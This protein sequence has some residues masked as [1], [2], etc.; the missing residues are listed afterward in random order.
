MY[1]YYMAFPEFLTTSVIS[2]LANWV[3]KPGKHSR[4]SDESSSGDDDGTQQVLHAPSSYP[5]VRTC[6]GAPA[7][8]AFLPLLGVTLAALACRQTNSASYSSCFVVF[9]LSLVSSCLFLVLSFLSRLL[10]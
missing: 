2:P 6:Q 10:V 4:S 9:F 3:G 1:Y 5:E 8:L 7:R